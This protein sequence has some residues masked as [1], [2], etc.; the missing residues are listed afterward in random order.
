M[1]NNNVTNKATVNEID[2]LAGRTATVVPVRNLSLFEIIDNEGWL[3]KVW[4]TSYCEACKMLRESL[5]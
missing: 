4:A 2:I 5:A 1:M 3:H